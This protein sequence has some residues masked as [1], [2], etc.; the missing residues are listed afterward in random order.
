[1]TI[2]LKKTA[3][4]IKKESNM[5]EVLQT[6]DYEIFKKHGQNRQIHQGNLCALMSSVLADNMLELRPILVDKDMRILDGQH[7]LEAAKRLRVPVWYQVK[8]ESSSEDIVLLN[9][10]QKRWTLEDYFNYF[11]ES[12]NAAYLDLRDFLEK[13]GI[14]FKFL[15]YLIPTGGRF[16]NSVKSGTKEVLSEKVKATAVFRWRLVCEIKE[17]ISSVCIQKDSVIN[18]VAFVRAI[19]ML[20]SK[21]NFREEKLKK[22]ILAKPEVLRV[23]GSYFGYYSILRE[24]HNYRNQEP[25]STEAPEGD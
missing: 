4:L 9:K 3:D 25:I 20:S 14:P 19:I 13:T 21:D 24:L 16:S 22:G 18:G 17:F 11:C 23:C 10:N 8:Q 1:M 7:R 6:T 5:V 12:G 2:R 15:T